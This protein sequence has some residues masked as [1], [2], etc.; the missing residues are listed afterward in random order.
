MFTVL[1]K[2]QADEWREILGEMK[3]AGEIKDFRIV[4]ESDYTG[5][6]YRIEYDLK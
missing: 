2:D 6:E 4:N 3:D 5:T 1:F